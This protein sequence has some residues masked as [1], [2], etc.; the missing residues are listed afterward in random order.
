MARHAT[1][2]SSGALLRAGL[3]MA[4]AGAALGVAAGAASA[5]EPPSGEVAGSA[6]LGGITDGLRSATTYGLGTVTHLQLD[7]LA[8]TGSDPLDNAVGTQIAD[9]KPLST[10][11]LTDPVTSGASLS[12]LPVLGSATGALG[13]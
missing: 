4:V 11:S 10:A 6:A 8:G 1:I 5:A 3:T 9:F 12:E 2:P 13:L 7:P